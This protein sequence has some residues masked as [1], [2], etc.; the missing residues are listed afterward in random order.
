MNY[1]QIAIKFAINNKLNRK[2]RHK[3]KYLFLDLKK[4]VSNYI[5][6]YRAK[7]LQRNSGIEI[8]NQRFRL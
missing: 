7:D 4:S 6:Y 5:I 8:L 2:P 3:Q 1:L